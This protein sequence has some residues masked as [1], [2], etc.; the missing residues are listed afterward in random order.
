MDT[1]VV[2]QTHRNQQQPSTTTTNLKNWLDRRST[3]YTVHCGS[4]PNHHHPSISKPP[5]N[6]IID[7][8]LCSA[9]LGLVRWGL[10]LFSLIFYDKI[11]KFITLP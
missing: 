9:G 6:I 1:I 5:P 2:A 4:A 8:F 11:V 3:S 10:D 7:H